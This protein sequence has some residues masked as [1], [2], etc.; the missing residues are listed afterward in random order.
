MGGSTD[1][2]ELQGEGHMT[3]GHRRKRWRLVFGSRGSLSTCGLLYRKLNNEEDAAALS[4]KWE[5]LSTA[6]DHDAS[7]MFVLL[8]YLFLVLTKCD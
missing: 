3:D 8:S 7:D 6:R 2:H 5:S 1:C 4:W